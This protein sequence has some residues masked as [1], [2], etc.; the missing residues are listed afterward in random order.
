MAVTKVSNIGIDASLVKWQS[1]K[2]ANFNAK[3]FEGY[4]VDTSSAAITVTLPVS[5]MSEHDCYRRLCIKL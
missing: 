2:T 4:W 3:A 1:V 5:P